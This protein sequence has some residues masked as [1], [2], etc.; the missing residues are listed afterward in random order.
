[1]KEADP[2]A[3]ENAKQAYAEKLGE[4]AEKQ[5]GGSKNEA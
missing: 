1:M 2:N 4:T 5:E 3:I